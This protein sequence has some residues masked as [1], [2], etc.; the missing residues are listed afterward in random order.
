MGDEITLYISDE[1]FYDE[2]A[3]AREGVKYSARHLDLRVEEI[4]YEDEN[5]LIVD[6][7]F[8]ETVHSGEPSEGT[9]KDKC[10][11]IDRVCGYLVK[12]G[13]YNP[14]L[15]QSFSPSLCHRLDRNTGGLIV[16]AKNAEALRIM[17]EKIRS[18]DI[19]KTY[20]CEVHGIPKIR[21]ATLSDFLYKDKNKNRAYIYKTQAEAKKALHIK[22]DDDIKA[23]IT[24]YR[25]VDKTKDT[26]LLSVELVTG[27]THQIRAHLAYYGYPL[28]GDGKYGIA[29]A[30]KYG[31]N[32]QHLYAY[33]LEF[34]PCEKKNLLSYLEG[35]TFA[36]HG[37]EF[38]KKYK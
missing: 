33:S 31:D 18:R 27:R 37:A 9:G 10:F 8:G 38:V 20:Y 2:T 29:H 5:I 32:F 19:V 30:K 3:S 35:K 11:L 15:E 24:K 4:V 12:K 7:P 28:V 21:E 34:L 13:E 36:G 25:V 17:N 6:K 1:F 16:C 26:A 22:Y 23:V 14:A